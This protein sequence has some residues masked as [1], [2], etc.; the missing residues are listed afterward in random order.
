LTPNTICRSHSLS[1][2]SRS[3]PPL[4]DFSDL[5]PIRPGNQTSRHDSTSADY[6]DHL[7]YMLTLSPLFIN[8]T[9][10]PPLGPSYLLYLVV[11]CSSHSNAHPPHPSFQRSGA[12]WSQTFLP[13]SLSDVFILVGVFIVLAFFADPTNLLSKDTTNRHENEGTLGLPCYR[14]LLSN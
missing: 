13:T 7:G 1:F 5:A 9:P 4:C 11:Y 2:R 14:T 10:P 12:S 8:H 3:L 6:F